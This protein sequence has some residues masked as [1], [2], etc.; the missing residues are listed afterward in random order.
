VKRSNSFR[1]QLYRLLH[2]EERNLANNEYDIIRA[3][4]GV[5]RL[6][7]ERKEIEAG[8][9]RI[10]RQIEAIERVNG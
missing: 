4:R 10:K 8:I 6:K 1:D 5:D 2:A 3:Q 7:N 9:E